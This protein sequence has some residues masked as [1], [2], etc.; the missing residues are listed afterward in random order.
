MA[1][2]KDT[3]ESP[4]AVETPKVVETMEAVEDVSPEEA[5]EFEQ[6]LQQQ[7]Q[8]SQLHPKSAAMAAQ[9]GELRTLGE[10]IEDLSK[11]I[12]PKYLKKLS[13]G[14]GAG[15]TYIPWPFIGKYLDHFAPGWEL[16]QS[17]L[18]DE[19]GATVTAVITIPTSDFG[20]VSRDG[21]GFEPHLTNK[22][23]ANE[24]LT[25]FGGPAPIASRMAAKRAAAE[26]SLGKYLYIK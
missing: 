6:E 9:A 8:E 15:S 24:K 18:S 12:H 1:T 10:I 7:K 23:T 19:H 16:S 22:G 14:G 25:G 3:K 4:K 20:K 2:K 5:A 21:I 26:F 13:K 17:V 11:P